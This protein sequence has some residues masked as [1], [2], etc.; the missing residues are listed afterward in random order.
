MDPACTFVS[1]GFQGTT[2]LILG[3]AQLTQSVGVVRR[4]V[5]LL[6]LHGANF[7]A[8]PAAAAVSALVLHDGGELGP[9]LQ[10]RDLGRLPVEV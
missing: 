4:P 5:L 9:L 3:F 2:E 1:K 7:E 8:G 10:Q 6:L